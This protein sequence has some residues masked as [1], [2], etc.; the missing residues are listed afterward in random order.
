MIPFASM[1]MLID[2]RYA[3]QSMTDG[4]RSANDSEIVRTLTETT[5]MILLEIDDLKEKL[6]TQ[7]PLDWSSVLGLSFLGSFCAVWLYWRLFFESL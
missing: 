6:S 7:K 4:S 2:T 5:K 1:E 3:Q